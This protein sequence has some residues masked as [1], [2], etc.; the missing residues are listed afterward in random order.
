MNIEYYDIKSQRQ[1]NGLWGTPI[2]LIEMQA[3]SKDVDWEL[4]SAIIIALSEC[5]NVKFK[6]QNQSDESCLIYFYDDV[7]KDKTIKNMYV[8]K[9]KDFL[10]EGNR[11]YYIKNEQERRYLKLNKL[12]NVKH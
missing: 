12:N 8:V 4:H 9:Y 1:D 11:L 2:N 10:L 3:I 6:I 7:F 5:H